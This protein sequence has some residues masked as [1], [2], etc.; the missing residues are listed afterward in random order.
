MQVLFNLPIMCD[1][2]IKF[3][4]GINFD[5]LNETSKEFLNVL[6]MKKEINEKDE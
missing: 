3:F 4:E 6:K 1:D 5:D 2:I